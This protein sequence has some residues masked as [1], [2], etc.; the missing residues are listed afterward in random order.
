MR[1]MGLA[2][3]VVLVMLLEK[4]IECFR[5]GCRAYTERT[6]RLLV[7]I[8]RDQGADRDSRPNPS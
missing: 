4:L 1:C 7:R 8:E 6:G 3:L 2:S 5:D